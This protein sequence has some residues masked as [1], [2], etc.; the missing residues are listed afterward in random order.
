ML[1]DL[2]EF[3]LGAEEADA[4]TAVAHAGFENPPFAV[5]G[6]FWGVAGKA[7]VELVRFEEG[8]VE[9]FGVVE[10]EDD[11][12]YGVGFEGTVGVFD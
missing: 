2:A 5:A 6:R 1:E 4:L 11:G 7:F 12:R 9:E 10:F 3:G 8:V